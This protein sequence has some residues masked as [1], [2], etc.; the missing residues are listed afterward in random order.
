M[1]IRYFEPEDFDILNYWLEKHGHPPATKDE[2]P[3]LGYVAYY[4]DEAGS[5]VMAAIAFI[6]LAEGNF[7]IADSLTL[8]PELKSL[9]SKARA[10]DAVTAKLIEVASALKIKHLLAYTE[11]EGVVK[12]SSKHGFKKIHHKLLVKSI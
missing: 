12:R 3:K 11:K 4:R 8:N 6:R 7:A 1:H 10:F 2:L 9:K 5:M